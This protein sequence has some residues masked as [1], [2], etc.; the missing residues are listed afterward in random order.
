MGAL[1]ER[2]CS[3]E[4]GSTER[5][6]GAP[7]GR[8]TMWGNCRDTRLCGR[9]SGV[10]QR[11]IWSPPRG[12]GDLAGQARRAPALSLHLGPVFQAQYVLEGPERV[13]ARL[14]AGQALTEGR[15]GIPRGFSLTPG[16]P[17][18]LGTRQAAPPSSRTPK[19]RTCVRARAG[20]LPGAHLLVWDAGCSWLLWKGYLNSS[21]LP[22]LPE[23][24]RI[25]LMG[26]VLSPMVPGTRGGGW[27][28]GYGTATVGDEAGTGRR[29]T[30]ERR[31]VD[32]GLGDRDEEGTGTLGDGDPGGPGGRW[33]RGGGGGVRGEGQ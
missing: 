13:L 33:G 27:G 3:R 25:T 24:T 31:N 20:W 18:L 23:L 9:G 8:C 32:G 21:L 4:G 10:A 1:R 15:R 12:E 2:G 17:R 11:G 30:G 19:S 22:L 28:R 14:E 26:L 6:K 29:G 5:G 16:T 7:A